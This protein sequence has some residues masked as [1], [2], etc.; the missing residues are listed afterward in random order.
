VGGLEADSG[1]CLQP[2]G[3]REQAAR[4]LVMLDMHGI[5]LSQHKHVMRGV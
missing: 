4:M 2:E 3:A 5:T 1:E